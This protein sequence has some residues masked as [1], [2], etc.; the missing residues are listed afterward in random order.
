MCGNKFEY[1]M[2]FKRLGRVAYFLS[3]ICL[4]ET[5]PMVSCGYS[6]ELPQWGNSMNTHKISLGTFPKLLQYL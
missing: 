1:S 6:L 2:S 3:Y 5:K 4:N